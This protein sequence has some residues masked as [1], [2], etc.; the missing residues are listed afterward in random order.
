MNI[1]WSL[2]VIFFVIVTVLT[3]CDPLMVLDPKGPQAQ[4][5]ANVIWISIAIMSV[6]TIVVCAFLVCVLVKYRDSKLPKDYEP[7]Y[8]EGNHLVE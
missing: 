7:P 2:L 3:G 4:T 1:K 5:Q 6:I 8:I